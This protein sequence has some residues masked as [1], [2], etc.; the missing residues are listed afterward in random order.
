MNKKILEEP[1]MYA[2]DLKNVYLT[3]LKHLG[4]YIKRARN[5]D[6]AARNHVLLSCIPYIMYKVRV[7]GKCGIEMPDLIHY[8][9]FGVV[10]AIEKMDF[11]KCKN[12]IACLRLHIYG[13]VYR[14]VEEV[15]TIVKLP[16]N[17]YS[18]KR[19]IHK[20][21]NSGLCLAEIATKVRITKK[22]VKEIL[23]NQGWTT[24]NKTNIN[25]MHL[26]SGKVCISNKVPT[27]LVENQAL[28]N[29]EQKDLRR[30]LDHALEKL[31][32]KERYLIIQ[33]YGL[34]NTKPKKQS[35]IAKEFGVTYQNISQKIR[36]ILKKLREMEELDS[37]R[38]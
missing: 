13:T 33:Y 12:P 26:D 9:I 28:S 17:T 19:R 18:I 35:E 29:L 38:P 34:R 7:F 32:P 2:E 4:P 23:E 8:G 27:C 37:V 21:L 1:S 25:I 6:I 31:T 10:R 30:C 22:A 36:R 11:T 20:Y 3:P 16:K 15:A 14:M 24:Q 5:G